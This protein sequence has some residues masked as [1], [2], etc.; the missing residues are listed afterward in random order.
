[1][2]SRSDAFIVCV[3]IELFW[4]MIFLENIASNVA[5]P[6]KVREWFATSRSRHE[7]LINSIIVMDTYLL[8]RDDM[9]FVSHYSDAIFGRCQFKWKI[10]NIHL[11]RLG[12]PLEFLFSAITI[13]STDAFAMVHGIHCILAASN[14]EREDGERVMCDQCT[15]YM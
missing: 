3:G 12:L 7:L 10:Q 2:F 4:I 14:R 11:T 5:S 8:R 6:M 15:L 1:M 9:T 13:G